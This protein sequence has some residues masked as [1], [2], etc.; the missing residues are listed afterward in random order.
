MACPPDLKKAYREESLLPF[1]GAGVSM[2]VRWLGTDGAER[3]GPS[4]AELVNSAA[5]M[6]GFEEADLARVRGTDLQILEYFK[7]KHAGQ[8]AKLTNWL[9]KHMSPSDD[10]IR[11]SMIHQQLSMLDKCRVYYTT[12]FDDLLE[13]ALRLNGRDPVVVA[14]EAEMGGQRRACEVVKFHGDW[15][16]PNQIVLTEMDYQERLSLTSHLD[17]RLRA[18]L[19]GRVVLFVGYSFRD[20]NVSYLFNLF[21]KDVKGKTE[22]RPGPRGFIIIPDPSDFEYQLFDERRIQVIPVNGATIEADIASCLA[23]MRS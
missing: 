22:T 4:W 11:T 19:L 16:H 12:N 8:T 21:I 2:S 20:P 10:A 14:V 23:E 7:R 5:N 13:R 1:I 17:L 3:R 15:D 6:L 18:D 9:T